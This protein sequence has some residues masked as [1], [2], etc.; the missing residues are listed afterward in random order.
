MI[1]QQSAAR[2]TS[3]RKQH[4]TICQLRTTRPLFFQLTAANDQN[5]N[6]GR[7]TTAT[8]KHAP[9]VVYTSPQSILGENNH[10]TLRCPDECIPL[11]SYV[12]TVYTTNFTTFAWRSL[13]TGTIFPVVFYFEKLLPVFWYTLPLAISQTESVCVIERIGVYVLLLVSILLARVQTMSMCPNYHTLEAGDA[14][15]RNAA[16]WHFLAQ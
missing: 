6:G 15:T 14:A 11:V 2:S 10:Q 12:D 9:H 4:K 5:S 16:V 13:T 1:N 8:T 3:S 7:G